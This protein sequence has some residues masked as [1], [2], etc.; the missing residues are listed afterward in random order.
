MSFQIE[1]SKSQKI[2]EIL[3]KEIRQ[4]EL[5][6]GSRIQSV[7]GLVERFDVSIKVVQTAFDT[8][9][10][11]DLI[12]RR[13]GSGTF[14]KEITSSSPKGKIAFLFDSSRNIE[15][16]YHFQVFRGLSKQMTS[17]GFSVE[18]ASELESSKLKSSY[19]GVILSSTI[20]HATM[21]R[22]ASEIPCVAYGSV[23]GIEG[24]CEVTPDYFAGSVMAVDHL[25]SL[26]YENII[27]VKFD[28]EE[29]VRSEVC[30]QG[31]LKG[32]KKNAISVSDKT[33]WPFSD[34]NSRLKLTLPVLKD[35]GCAIYIP[36][37]STAFEISARL[38]KNG[39]DIPDTI[40]LMG[41]YDRNHAKFANP[42][43]TTIGFDHEQ[44]GESAA[45]KLI[46][47]ITGSHPES[48]TIPV[49]IVQ[50]ESVK[51]IENPIAKI[52]G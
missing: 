7:R 8:L 1:K 27:F 12:Q 24:L 38:Q 43:L 49:H 42:P 16:A 35:G 41:F 28:K 21:R 45:S 6:S 37:D 18:I 39:L 50:R 32:L 13:H 9:E 31:F 47:L 15:E 34:F 25:R 26:G 46:D 22:I 14:V 48:G 4:G 10:K 51:A 3:E 23:S 11:K 20:N 52:G 33:I 5:P 30:L 2:A 19:E 44:M 29:N 36:S 40:G 17:N